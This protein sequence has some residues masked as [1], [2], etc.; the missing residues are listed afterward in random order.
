MEFYGLADTDQ[1][2]H[3]LGFTF[4]ACTVTAEWPR[5]LSLL[6]WLSN[7]SAPVLFLQTN[8]KTIKVWNDNMTH[9]TSLTG[10]EWMPTM[11]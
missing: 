9:W 11:T 2:K 8:H 3:A 6:S 7:V 10:S 5:C 1:Q 4:S